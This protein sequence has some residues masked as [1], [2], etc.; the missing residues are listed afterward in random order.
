MSN[1]KQPP[2]PNGWSFATEVAKGIFGLLNTGRIIPAFGILILC[3]VGLAVWRLPESDLAKVSIAF[4][5]YLSSSAGIAYTLLFSTNVG[6]LWLLKR[7]KQIY[8]KEMDR[9][10][11]MRSKLF[12]LG[13]DQ[14]LIKN[15]RSSNG[16]QREG[17]I[18]PDM[19]HDDKAKRG[20]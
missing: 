3:I 7:Q 2:A 9:L 4:F 11:D 10:A 5:D 8:E 16:E 12:H 18:L 20:S 1:K 17:Y 13:A 15:H 6:W 14:V 19:N